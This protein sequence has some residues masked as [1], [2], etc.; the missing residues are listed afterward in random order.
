MNT[1]KDFLCAAVM[2]VMVMVGGVLGMNV[3]DE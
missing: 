3:G 2:A 1:T